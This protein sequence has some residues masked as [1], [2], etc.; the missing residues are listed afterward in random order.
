MVRGEQSLSPVRVDEFGMVVGHAPCSCA[1][2]KLHEARAACVLQQ[3]A[4][5]S[6]ASHRHFTQYV[7]GPNK[8]GHAL[9]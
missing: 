3:L 4:S 5:A 7:C 6:L 9:A 8:I 2:V 1:D